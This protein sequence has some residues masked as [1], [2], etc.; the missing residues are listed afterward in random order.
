MN[1]IKYPLK[2][3]LTAAMIIMPVAWLMGA[4][5][6]SANFL[7]MPV[8]VRNVAMGETGAA[9][10][11][12]NS[13]YYNPAGLGWLTR[14]ELTFAHTQQLQG[15]SFEHVA[16][17]LPVNDWGVFGLSV[18]Y[19]GSGDV[20]GYGV[21]GAPTGN[22]DAYYSAVALSFGRYVMGERIEGDGLTAGGSM[23]YIF[24][25]LDTARGSAFGLDL[26]GLYTFKPSQLTLDNLFA[27]GMS[28]N[29]IGTNLKY[30]VESDPLPLGI[31]FGMMYKF[32]VPK[33]KPVVT[34]DINKY[35]D[36]DLYLGLG[37]EISIKDILALRLGY[38]TK[39]SRA[40][41]TGLRFGVGLKSY[42]L[43]FDYAYAGFGDLGVTHRF[44]LTV[45]FDT[46]AGGNEP[47]D[48]TKIF[49]HGIELFNQERYLESTL[50]F[51]KVLEIDPTNK[52]ALKYMQDANKKM[53]EKR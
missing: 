45:N 32:L 28:V 50:E 11:D 2:I 27:V 41:D 31:R 25:R 4:G 3:V 5:T 9:Q 33:I 8:G 24:S 49:Q 15:V 38:I 39:G 52:E 22:V 6:T 48:V 37:G 40:T 17:I 13:A 26:G 19:L 51:N 46:R 18:Y 16:G 53:N 7:K 35:R 44:G 36:S 12:V 10:S 20:Q 29:N 1:R 47:V 14:P 23:K 30:D 42:G 21:T 43:A 34:L